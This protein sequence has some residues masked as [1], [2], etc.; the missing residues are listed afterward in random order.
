[1]VP[2]ILPHLLQQQACPGISP[3]KVNDA[4]ECWVNEEEQRR[5]PLG[6]PAQT[7]YDWQSPSLSVAWPLNQQG[8]PVP[9]TLWDAQH[10]VV[11][12][13]LAAA[14]LHPE[15][16]VRKRAA[17]QA[18]RL[19]TAVYATTL[20]PV[21]VAKQGQALSG[22]LRAAGWTMS[23]AVRMYRALPMA[24]GTDAKVMWSIVEGLHALA[25]SQGFNPSGTFVPV[26]P[27]DQ[28]QSPETDDHGGCGWTSWM[29]L[30]PY[31]R[32]LCEMR[33]LSLGTALAAPPLLDD[34]IDGA[35]DYAEWAFSVGENHY[36][37]AGKLPDAM[38]PVRPPFFQKGSTMPGWSVAGLR[39]ADAQGLLTPSLKASAVALCNVT[40]YLDDKK[41]TNADFKGLS[42]VLL[43][44]GW[45][46]PK[47]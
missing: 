36:G 44:L 30:G 5:L 15:K 29:L 24:D 39:E 16:S 20:D 4:Y 26:N 22:N 6:P 32:G 2:G 33:E 11:D 23:F 21:K 28:A 43:R 14:F 42:L 35:L 12:Q 25:T 10:L 1:M 19:R 7:F 41:A 38:D 9:I 18:D 40:D 13:L 17:I 45:I 34:L 46:G 37:I 31:L 27:A 8:K 3:A 47:T